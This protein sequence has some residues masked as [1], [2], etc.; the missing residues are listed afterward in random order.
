MPIFHPRPARTPLLVGLEWFLENFPQ[1]CGGGV[2][3]TASA[4]IADYGA[5]SV[6]TLPIG[7]LS[8]WPLGVVVRETVHSVRCWHIRQRRLHAEFLRASADQPEP[9][10]APAE[11]V[12]VAPAPLPAAQPRPAALPPARS[13][14]VEGEVVEREPRR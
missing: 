4:T 10:H 6:V 13:L 2:L 12:T 3:I 7:L 14:V 5:P 8:A 1:L 11:R 9:T